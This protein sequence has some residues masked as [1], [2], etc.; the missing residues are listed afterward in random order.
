[1]CAE[2]LLLLFKVLVHGH[3]S[4]QLLEQAAEKNCI[5]S[6]DQIQ[7]KVKIWQKLKTIIPPQLFKTN[8]TTVLL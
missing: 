3:K 8:N 4:T 7:L 1:M 6:V 5:S 2:P